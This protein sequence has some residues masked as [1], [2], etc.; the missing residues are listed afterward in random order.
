[1]K[2][3]LSVISAL[4]FL[5]GA[6]GYYVGF[7]AAD[8]EVKDEMRASIQSASDKKNIVW[9]SFS[10]TQMANEVRFIDNGEFIYNG[11]HYDVII[12]K[13]I[14]GK[15]SYQCVSDD[16]ETSLFSWFKKN[17]D[18]QNSKG[19]GG[20]ISFNPLTLDWFFQ[21][22]AIQISTFISENFALQPQLIPPSFPSEIPTPPPNC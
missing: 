15:I 11:K 19:S 2:K 4:V 3:I 16:R 6:A 21:I 22:D 20:K 13:N 10:P 9:L 8:R 14:D 5:L 17:L 1:V 7:T 18:H 12:S